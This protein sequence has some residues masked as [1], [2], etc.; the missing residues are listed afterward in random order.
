MVLLEAGVHRHQAHTISLDPLATQGGRGGWGDV[1]QTP[2]SLLTFR[3]FLGFGFFVCLFVFC[4]FR[5]CFLWVF[6]F[7]KILFIYSREIQREREAET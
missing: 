4:F 5:F 7:L 2:D 3:G 6:F 1:R